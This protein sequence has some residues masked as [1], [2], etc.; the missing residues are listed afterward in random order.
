MRVWCDERVV[1]AKRVGA[2]ARPGVRARMHC[3]SRAHPVLRQTVWGLFLS[4]SL[5]RAGQASGAWLK[6]K[7]N[8]SGV[9]MRDGRCRQFLDHVK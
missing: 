3:E 6:S 7:Q 4:Y 9:S 1:L 5:A 2:I 8:A